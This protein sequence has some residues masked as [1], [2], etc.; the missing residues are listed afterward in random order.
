[1]PSDPRN[2]MDFFRDPD[3]N[4]ADRDQMWSMV[5]R[6]M[7]RGEWPNLPK[8][9][10][11]FPIDPTNGVNPEQNAWWDRFKNEYRGQTG[12]T[13]TKP[14]DH[15]LNYE[16]NGAGSGRMDP[17]EAAN[18]VKYWNRSHPPA[19][20]FKDFPEHGSA[21]GWDGRVYELHHQ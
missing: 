20:P 12:G 19:E 17:I 5:R 16:Y 14:G 21:P 18:E 8:T 2:F 11:G 1:M 3:L 6:M 9:P 15:G 7:L 10:Q 13:G 4:H